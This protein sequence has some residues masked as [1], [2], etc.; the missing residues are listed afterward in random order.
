MMSRQINFGYRKKCLHH[1]LC[2]SF[3]KGIVILRREDQKINALKRH[4][5]E[6]KTA[7]AS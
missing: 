4:I 7:K 2:Y 5:S 3:V 1:T 6:P